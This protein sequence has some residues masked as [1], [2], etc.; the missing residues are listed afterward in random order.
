MK[1]EIRSCRIRAT[2]IRNRCSLLLGLAFA[3]HLAFALPA[4]AQT[5]TARH[6]DIPAGP[7]DATLNRFALQTG[8]PLAIDAEK[9]KGLRSDGLHGDYDIAGG[10][11]A[12]LRGS[13]YTMEQTASGYILVAIPALRTGA[14]G[15]S[16]SATAL[17]PVLVVDG[18]EWMGASTIDRHT[19]EA[20]PG[21][22]GDITSLLKINPSVAFDN[23]Q[24]S[25]KTPGEIAP[26]DISINGAK[27]Y[28][29]AFVVDGVNMN[30]D[31]D[32]GQS[33]PNLLADV[34]GR[35]QGLALDTDLLESIVVYDSNVPA[36]Y[37][38]FNGGVV[39]ANTRR[40]S[41]EPSGKISYQSTRS[42]WT[43]Y[44][45]D[46][47][48]QYSFENSGNYNEQPEFDKTIVRA[49]L[50]GHLTDNFGLLANISQKRSSMPTSFYSSNNVA[51]MGSEKRDQKREI[52]NYFVKA[53]WK[54]ADRLEIESSLAYAPENNIYWRSNSANSSFET[55]SGG[56]QLNLKAR[57][58]GDLAKVEHNLSY[59][60]LE[61]SRDSA[62][63]DWFTWR[64]STT[65]DWGIGNTATTS[66]NEGGYGDVDQAQK[67]LSYRIN[68]DW[69]SFSLLGATHRLQTGL[70]LSRQYVRYARLTESSTYVTPVATST[71]TNGSGV[72]DSV[73]CDI[74]T[75]LAGWNGQFFT[76]RTRYATGAFDFTTNQ[77]TAWLQ[78]EIDFGKLN[79]RPGLR[80]DSDDYMNKTTLAPRLAAQYDV[81]ADRGTVL[82]AGANRYYGRSITSW[83]LQE[84]RNQ[85]R[86]NTEKRT[87]LDDAWT[88]G[89]QATNLVKFSELEIPYD[90]ELMAGIGQRWLGAQYDLKYVNRKGRDQVIQV[91]GTSIGQ[92]ST[93]PTLSPSYTTYTNG[94]RSETDIV[95]LT[96]TPLQ[97]IRWLGTRTTGQLALDWTDKKQNAPDYLYDSVDSTNYIL[98]PYIQY[99]G[100]IMRYADRPADNYNRP[101]TLR[102]S[103]LTNIPQW[104]LTWTNFLRYR[105]A[106]SKIAQTTSAASSPIVHDGQKVA[107]W[108]KRKF[109][110]AL[111]W[112]MRL[113][114]EIPL[115]R[116]QALFV[117]L[118][119]FNVLD[120][121]SVADSN[122]AISTGIPV[123][124]VG[125]QFWLEVGY[126]F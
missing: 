109:S 5:P 40:P 61:Q 36:A 6:Y 14:S 21:G 54:P 107:I 88:L 43:R 101:W 1:P 18:R 93:D 27:F 53:F 102:L 119:V 55:Q 68:A 10:F 104:N 92:P 82:N 78:D 117:N 77:Q 65:K 34:P 87:T 59:G 69:K 35:S 90:D 39:E 12:L 56:T 33:N 37:G 38:R 41:K 76:Q 73:A 120:A 63:D 60:K 70:E 122:T 62:Y 26:A 121:V 75:T 83:R 31:I 23:L 125:R 71:C 85:L 91:S 115:A 89:T 84:G 123:Y 80:L 22:N 15:E 126:R 47:A 108:S 94:G 4:A 95:T 113:G 74:G 25:S 3:G 13:G 110:N 58:D 11:A 98:N 103:S 17:A 24:L 96:V 106:Y 86:Y 112:D 46:E 81:F 57:W 111:T 19:I 124:E 67:T 9:L 32:P 72:T 30:N 16:G 99:N 66:S 8:V 2:A 51:A 79:L 97:E 64:K 28:Q 114:W 29:N 49:T 118:D 105:A 20:Q 7:L 44:H 116:K 48:Q 52:D 50:E 100:Q 42:S 45:I